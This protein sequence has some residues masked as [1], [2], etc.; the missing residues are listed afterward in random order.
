MKDAFKILLVEDEE[1]FRNA[2]FELLG[3]FNDVETAKDLASAREIL[4]SKSF[5]VVLLDKFLPDGNGL[6][7]IPEIKAENPNSVVIILTGDTD[8]SSVK[9]C[10]AAGA[11]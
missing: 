6:G 2:A 1:S 8:F 5:D 10:I 9:K 7:L 11:D 3:V 4:Q